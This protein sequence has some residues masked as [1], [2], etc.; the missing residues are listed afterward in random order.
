MLMRIIF[1]SV[2]RKMEEDDDD[3]IDDEVEWTPTKKNS[4]QLDFS[5]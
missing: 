5:K 1:I 4:P 2:G 3:E